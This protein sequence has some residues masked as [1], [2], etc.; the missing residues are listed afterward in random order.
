MAGSE[1]RSF[2]SPAAATWGPGLS[3]FIWKDCGGW[4]WW[5]RKA[6]EGWSAPRPRDFGAAG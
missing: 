2:P 5:C 4:E 1:G 6:R 3:T